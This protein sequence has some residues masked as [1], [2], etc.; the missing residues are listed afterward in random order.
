MRPVVPLQAPG[1]I[2]N[3]V[4]PTGAPLTQA[5]KAWVLNRPPGVPRPRPPRPG[6]IVGFRAHQ[7][8]RVV[9]ARVVEVESLSDPWAHEHDAFEPHGPDVNVWRVRT[10]SA[11]AALYDPERPGSYLFELAPDPWPS[12]VLVVEPEPGAKGAHTFTVTREARLPGSRGWTT[13]DQIGR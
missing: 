2:G 6:E 9:P 11:G 4:H 3:T 13:P 12:V 5:E 8:G 7:G 1:L 10:N